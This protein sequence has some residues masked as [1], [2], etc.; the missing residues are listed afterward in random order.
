VQVDLALIVADDLP[1]ATLAAA[2]RTHAGDLLEDLELF[3]EFRGQGV[4]K[5]QRSLAWRLTF[6]H[7]ERTLREKEIDAR[8]TKLLRAL[9]GELGVRQRTS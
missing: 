2:I 6:R 7:P 8:K 5:G 9:E 1:A 4:E 3:D